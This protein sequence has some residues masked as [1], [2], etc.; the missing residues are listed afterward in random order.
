[1]NHLL[2]KV[3]VAHW[4]RR[5]LPGREHGFKSPNVLQEKYG[6]FQT[7]IWQFS[8]GGEL[9]ATFKLGVQKYG[10]SPATRTSVATY[11]ILMMNFP[12]FPFSF[13]PYLIPV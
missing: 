9:M 4:Y 5:A 6:N 13:V 11:V 7:E 2:I 3:S 1:M 12:F 10:D 8:D